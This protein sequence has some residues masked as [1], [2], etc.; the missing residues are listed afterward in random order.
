MRFITPLY[1]SLWNLPWLKDNRHAPKKAWGYFLVVMAVISAIFLI[2]LAIAL[3]QSVQNMKEIATTK[4]PA[5]QAVWTNG[6]LV[7]TDLQQPYIIKDDNFVVV[8]DTISTTTIDLHKYLET[9]EQKGLLITRD[10]MVITDGATGKEQS[11][12]WRND[13][14]LTVTKDQVASWV[15]T[16]TSAGYVVLF[17][18]IVLVVIFVGLVAG[19]LWS[20]VVVTSVVAL[21]STFMSRGWHWG[22]LFT[23]GLY[24]TTLPMVAYLALSLVGV[25]ING[26]RFMAL[27][28]F[29]LAVAFT[30]DKP[31]AAI[32]LSDE[33]D[34]L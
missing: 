33:S 17:G 32:D 24:G 7:V 31:E 25:E 6:N 16:H 26:V 8:V 29:M 27:L 13:F 1:N 34:S 20:L 3:P 18:L 23:M 10:K 4:L 15:A 11:Q 12:P 2:P 21:L 14:S 28:A 30:D 9:K 5:F 19:I 22:E